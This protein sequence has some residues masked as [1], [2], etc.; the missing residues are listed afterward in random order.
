LKPGDGVFARAE[1][2]ELRF[3][4][5]VVGHGFFDLLSLTGEL[6]IGP[7]LARE[8]F[9]FDLMEQ[10]EHHYFDHRHAENHEKPRLAPFDGA[11]DLALLR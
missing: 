6:G 9:A 1:D 4:V 10:N 2:L 11:L 8:L 3:D 7:H 5:G